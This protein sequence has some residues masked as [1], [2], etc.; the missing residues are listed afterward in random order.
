MLFNTH[1]IFDIPVDIP[2]FTG[3]EFNSNLSEA[4]G[5]PG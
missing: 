1:N 4:S 2:E 5:L 3:N